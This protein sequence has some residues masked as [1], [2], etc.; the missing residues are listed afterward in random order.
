MSDQGD[1]GGRP[2]GTWQQTEAVLAQVPACA[3]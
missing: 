3:G 2:P 1:L